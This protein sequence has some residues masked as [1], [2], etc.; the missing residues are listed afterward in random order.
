LAG[1]KLPIQFEVTQLTG[2]NQ[3]I[4]VVENSTFLVPQ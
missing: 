3:A 1:Q 2:Q 4:K